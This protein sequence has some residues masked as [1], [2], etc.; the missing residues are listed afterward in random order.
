MSWGEIKHGL[1][2]NLR[3]HRVSD[4]ALVMRLVMQMEVLCEPVFDLAP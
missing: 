3:F 1:T 2:E 4:E